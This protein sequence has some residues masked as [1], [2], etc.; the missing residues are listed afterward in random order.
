MNGQ[1]TIMDK[2]RDISDKLTAITKRQL[3]DFEAVEAASV[4]IQNFSITG[5]PHT[6]FKFDLVNAGPTRA[7]KLQIIDGYTTGPPISTLGPADRTGI[8]IMPSDIGVSIGAGER[9]S[10]DF[11]IDLFPPAPKAAKVPP[12]VHWPTPE[13]IVRGKQGVYMTVAI[14]YRDVFLKDHSTSDCLA[15]ARSFGR[16]VPCFGGHFMR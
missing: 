4:R 15:Y 1:R 14:A 16:W 5:F 8:M 11:K 7:D 12:R 6:R 9:R 13:G 3:D 2:Q 10:Y